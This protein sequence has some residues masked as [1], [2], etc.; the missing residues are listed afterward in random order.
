MSDMRGVRSGWGQI[1]DERVR[2]L[3]A[4]GYRAEHD[5]EHDGGEL[6]RCAAGFLGAE[7]PDAPK[8]ADWPFGCCDWKPKDRIR[9]LVRAGALIAA[10][11]DRLQRAAA[12][13]G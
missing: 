7:G 9:N 6:A 1:A 2:Q 13:N 11:I 8:P 10:E 12:R 5:D 4:E 3:D